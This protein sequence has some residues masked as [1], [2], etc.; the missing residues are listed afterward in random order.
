MTM[1]GRNLGNGI[2]AQD[3]TSA[4]RRPQDLKILEEQ[5]HDGRAAGGGEVGDTRIISEIEGS[6]RE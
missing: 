3:M 1:A 4:K 2:G 5:R 6:A